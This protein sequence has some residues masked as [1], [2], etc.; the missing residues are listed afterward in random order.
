MTINT[1]K[2]MEIGYIMRMSCG[3]ISEWTG[4]KYLHYV[5]PKCNLDNGKTSRIPGYEYRVWESMPESLKEKYGFLV[6]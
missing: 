1:S 3:C 6:E 2:Y 4:Q 5:N